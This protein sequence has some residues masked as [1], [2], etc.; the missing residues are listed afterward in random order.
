MKK[1]NIVFFMIIITPYLWG[2]QKKIQQNN[3]KSVT[4]TE[5]VY[6]KGV[7]KKYLDSETKYDTKGNI[8]EE[9]EYKAGK[10]DRHVIYKYDENSNKISETELDASGKKTKIT[11]YKY[12]SA[13]L[14]IEKTVYDGNKVL[15]SKK[16]YQY[17]TY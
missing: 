5:Y 4:V 7:E 12:N 13:N 17:T 2:Q 10:I 11:E 6:E 1:I 16:I 15:K 8:I 9:I 3:I 14:R